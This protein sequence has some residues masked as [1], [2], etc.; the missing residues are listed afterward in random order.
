MAVR[1]GAGEKARVDAISGEDVGVRRGTAR[2]WSAACATCAT[3]VD[4]GERL[5]YTKQKDERSTPPKV[6]ETMD[7]YLVEES[8]QDADRHAAARRAGGRREGQAEAPWPAA[9]GR[10]VSRR[11][12]DTQQLIARLEVVS[13]RDTPAL[14]NAVEHYRIPMRYLWM[15]IAKLQEGLGGKTKA[16]VI[17]VILALSLIGASLYAFPYA[18]Q[19]DATG[20]VLPTVRRT[21]YCADA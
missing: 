1:Q 10:R 20:K 8:Q 2:T 17:L 18:L 11:P 4:W 14:Y 16:I 6:L 9:S 19:M 12:P 15:P 13:R 5:I 3:R 21:V 7:A